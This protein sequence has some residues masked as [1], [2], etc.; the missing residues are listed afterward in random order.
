[1]STTT[2]RPVQ[3]TN[4]QYH[5]SNDGHVY[6]AKHGS[7]LRELNPSINNSGYQVVNLTVDGQHITKS[8]HMLVAEAFC[9]KPCDCD[10][11][12]TV[13]H[14]SGNK[15][16]CRSENLRWVCH[17][18]NLNNPA[19][20]YKMHAPKYT[21]KVLVVAEG[22]AMMFNNISEAARE[23][24]DITRGG[25]HHILD[26]EHRDTDRQGRVFIRL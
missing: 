17:S 26:D 11:Y 14:I 2:I 7:E 19:T 25:I 9:T 10:G 16:D 4:N 23:L 21:G 5:I 18:D 24:G 6:S 12:L 13:D 8:V 20:N 3:G 15:L 22:V 1:M